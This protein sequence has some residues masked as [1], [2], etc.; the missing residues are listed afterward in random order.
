M[1]VTNEID[2]RYD[3]KKGKALIFSWTRYG[4]RTGQRENLDDLKLM[5]GTLER[6]GFVVE[7]YKNKD[8]RGTLDVLKQG[9]YSYID[10]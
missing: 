7:P 5:S 6:N 4:S 2:V 1:N 3:F 8:R 10:N 9:N